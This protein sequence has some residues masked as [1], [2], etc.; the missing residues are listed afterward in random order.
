MMWHDG[1]FARHTRFRY[2]LLDASLRLM[3]PGMQRTFFR[4]REAARQYTLADLDDK[5]TRRNLVQQMSTNQLPGSIGER[6]KMRQE[7][8]AMVHQLEAE[9]ADQGENAGAGRIPA[10]VCTLTCP[11]YK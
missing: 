11:V 8:Q 10:G 1:R 3:T 6:R 9:T 7:L 4:T 2:W 5:Q